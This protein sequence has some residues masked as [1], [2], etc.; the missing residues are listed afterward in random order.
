MYWAIL[1][2]LRGLTRRNPT[3]FRGSLF[4]ELVAYV[5]VLVG[6]YTTPLY[7]PTPVGA[8][9]H[10]YFSLQIKAKHVFE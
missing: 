2:L 9:D 4:F 7:S 1:R 3:L 10:D 6:K 5:P 8:L